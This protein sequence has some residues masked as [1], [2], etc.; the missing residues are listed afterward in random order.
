MPY[1]KNESNVKEQIMNGKQI[2]K[3]AGELN[4]FVTTQCLKWLASQRAVSR[5]NNYNQFNHVVGRLVEIEKVF[6]NFTIDFDK[7][8]PKE[9]KQMHR[10]VRSFMVDQHENNF[11][12]IDDVLNDVRGVL[13]CAQLEMYRRLI[14]TYEDKKIKENGDVYPVDNGAIL[15]STYESKIGG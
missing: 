13:R 5:K 12:P 7:D 11:V 6:S 2:P 1:I 3:N 8:M 4:Y 15:W 10:T 14:A 9:F